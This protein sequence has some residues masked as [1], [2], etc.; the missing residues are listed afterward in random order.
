M[1][2]TAATRALELAADAA[3]YAPSIHN[4]QPWRWVVRAPALELYAERSRQLDGVDPAG[5][6]LLLSCGTALH[7]AQVALDAEGWRYDVERSAGEPLAVVRAIVP[8]EVDPVA[9]RHFQTTLVR[10]TDRRAVTD[11][12][13]DETALRAV[14]SAA[15]RYGARMHVLRGDEVIDLAVAVEHAGRIE[16]L[17]P[18]VQDELA[19]WVGGS[20]P[21]ATGVPAAAIP[22]ENPSATVA[23]RD[24]GPDGLLNAGSGH[25]TAAVYAVLY[26][27]TDEPAA[28]L[29]AGE[30]L[31]A[32]W[33]AAVEAGLSLLPFSAP[34]EVPST[35][36]ALRRSLSGV[37]YPYLAMRL[38]V[39]DPEHGG[40]P[41][42]PRLGV[43]QTVEVVDPAG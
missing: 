33:L 35:R 19:A 27:D 41:G 15:E 25:D 42:T 14:L 16:S 17:D 21:S 8:G 12:P 9:M 3:R 2:L 22:V 26:G 37:G 5:E 20:R 18:R 40:P 30:A 28:W 4:T 24:F 6:L 29:R 1:D 39:M 10:R 34:I 23:E 7:H 43:E 31:S 13:V 11:E 36:Q 38:G 32:A